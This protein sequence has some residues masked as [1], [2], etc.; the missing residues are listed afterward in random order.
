MAKL[1]ATLKGLGQPILQYCRMIF[2]GAPAH[3]YTTRLQ[4]IHTGAS[5]QRERGR[6]AGASFEGSFK[7]VDPLTQAA[8]S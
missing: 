2:S 6:C 1:Q 5:A 3:G 8:G 7:N 4:R